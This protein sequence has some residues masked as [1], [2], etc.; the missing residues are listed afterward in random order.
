MT[1]TAVPQWPK[2]SPKNLNTLKGQPTYSPSPLNT[3][4]RP[5]HIPP[6][7]PKPPKT[8]RGWPA[9]SPTIW[10]FV[11]VAMCGYTT[12]LPRL[13]GGGETGL[14]AT[15]Q[16]CLLN[17]M[18]AEPSKN[19]GCRR[20]K[21]RCQADH[22]CACQGPVCISASRAGHARPH[23][24]GTHG[25][26]MGQRPVAGAAD[27]ISS[28]KLSESNLSASSRTSSR[29]PSARSVPLSS[30]AP[31]RPGVPTATWHRL[32]YTRS[33]SFHR[34]TIAVLCEEKDATLC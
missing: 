10:P 15:A 23:F 27:L 26:D 33:A 34:D 7:K 30:S 9:C 2:P 1:N 8:P 31:T 20:H 25:G 32:Q 28:R 29:M 3:L 6:K 22:T 5:A 13:A 14:D 17:W 18:D 11:V 4:K 19:D 12:P 21:R 16:Q 24:F